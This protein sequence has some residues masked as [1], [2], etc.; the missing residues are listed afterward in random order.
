MSGDAAGTFAQLKTHRREV[1]EPNTA[2]YHGRVVK[3]TGDGELVEFPSIVNAVDCAI[4][5]QRA[6]TERAS[7]EQIKLRIG[8]N[9]GGIFIEGSDIYGDGVNVAARIQE[10][11]E[12]GGV[13]LYL[14]LLLLHGPVIGLSALPA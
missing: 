3:L 13:A 7:G 1:I 12:P 5:V 8:I 11:A 2:E 14:L 6:L 9:L 10:V 4:A